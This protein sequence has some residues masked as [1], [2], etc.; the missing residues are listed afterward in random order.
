MLH[1]SITA[2]TSAR[3]AGLQTRVP[4]T[5]AKARRCG[6][7]AHRLP[8]RGSPSQPRPFRAAAG[9]G[10]R[11]KWQQLHEKRAVG[12]GGHPCRLPKRSAGRSAP[13]S[14]EEGKTT[15][16][17]GR[18]SSAAGPA[19][20]ESAQSTTARRPRDPSI[21]QPV[22]RSGSQR[23]S[24]SRHRGDISAATPA[25]RDD[26]AT[27]R[28]DAFAAGKSPRGKREGGTR[29][30]PAWRGTEHSGLSETR[31]E[32]PGTKR[33][34]RSARPWGEGQRQ[35]VHGHGESVEVGE[36][37]VEE[38]RRRASGAWIARSGRRPPLA[39]WPTTRHPYASEQRSRTTV[40]SHR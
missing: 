38:G 10:R 32:R 1:R 13:L 35:D 4:D 3:A 40:G 11:G 30:T 14:C 20:T 16:N 7:P 6:P 17:P 2:A 9:C 22:S 31:S 36:L 37:D 28:R 5:A 15:A 27:R 19:S 12:E 18:S 33:P 39:A 23:R 8:E 25:A 34:S 24:R 21:V 29:Q 26:G